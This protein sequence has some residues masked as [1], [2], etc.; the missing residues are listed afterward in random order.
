MSKLGAMNDARSPPAGMTRKQWRRALN[1]VDT[2]RVS[3]KTATGI[4]AE[5]GGRAVDWQTLKTVLQAKKPKS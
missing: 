4:L 1:Q 2:A 3:I 5:R